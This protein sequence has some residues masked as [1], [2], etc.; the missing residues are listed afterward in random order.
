MSFIL[1]LV[2][3]QESPVL[4]ARAI[5]PALSLP[6]AD[7]RRWLAPERACD[8]AVAERPEPLAIEDLRS[9][10]DPLAVD[11]FVTRAENRQK[12]LLVADMEST[13][14]AFEALEE[15]AAFLNIRDKIKAITD[16]A[17]NGELDFRAALAERTALLKGVPERALAEVFEGMKS[18]VNPGA[19]DLVATM[20]AHGA[21][22][23]LVTGG[24]TYFA[25]WVAREIGFDACHANPLEIE[26]GKISGRLVEPV[27]G[28]DAKL[29][30]LHR[31]CKDPG[32][33]PA[34]AMTIGDGANDIPMLLAAQEAGG[35][36][37]GYRPKPA[38]AK[39]GIVNR[40]VHGDLTAA[41]FAQGYRR[42]NDVFI[43][44]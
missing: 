5:A 12:T 8:I 30:Y 20:K 26:D 3:S 34:D 10:F 17:M 6:G 25:E 23:V 22:C 32:I 7:M 16:R 19:R 14:V 33:S 41:L 40:I 42:E 43:S 9:V 44:E 24:F 38:I 37:V 13:M 11:L 15:I 4:T 31:Y 36:G 39:A 27:L 18:T 1:T 21:R 29:G 28:P 2:A 35:L